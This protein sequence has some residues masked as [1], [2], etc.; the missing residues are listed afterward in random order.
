MSSNA[1]SVPSNGSL[2]V[3]EVRCAVFLGI[4]LVATVVG[5][6]YSVARGPQWVQWVAVAVAV[7][8][9]VGLGVSAWRLHRVERALKAA[10]VA[11]AAGS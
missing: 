3:H 1:Q 4:M 8:A 5:V 9:A 6:L 10:G 11:E 7:P 2:V